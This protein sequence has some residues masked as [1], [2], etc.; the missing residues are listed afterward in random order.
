M[1]GSIAQSGWAR[2][3]IFLGLPAVALA[4]IGYF[5]WTGR[6]SH[7]VQSADT[8][9]WGQGLT[10]PVATRPPP[11]E[12][13]E[14][15]PV[16]AQKQEVIPPV[17]PLTQVRMMTV[18]ESKEAMADVNARAAERYQERMRPKNSGAIAES[19]DPNVLTPGGG[20]SEY[21]QRMRS[22]DFANTAPVPPNLPPQYTIKKNARIPCL[23]DSPL[24]SEMVGPITCLTTQPV[25][26]MDGNNVLLPVGT[27]V[28]GTIERGLNNGE[29]RL[30]PIW[31]DMLTPK[32]YQLPIPLNAP[33]ADELGVPGL[34]GDVSTHF[35]LKARDLALVSVI[36]MVGGVASSAASS[37]R[38][39]NNFNLNTNGLQNSTQT[40]AQSAFG[41]EIGQP[42][43]L[44]R[45][46]GQPIVIIVNKYINLSH[47]YR[48]VVLR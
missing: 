28:H 27:E 19:T 7:A 37:G 36:D 32:P 39:N 23:P 18:F 25:Y 31:T 46:Q 30:F 22:T 12:K 20:Q 3:G 1:S 26:S 45:G 4:G 40:L 24:S 48:N 10:L 9:Q 43:T 38:N 6:T 8:R 34:P 44:Y 21:A 29:R 14:P 16:I 5:A 41:K 11:A 42:D 47:Y 35:W 33:S 13:A 17:A 2:A 15:E